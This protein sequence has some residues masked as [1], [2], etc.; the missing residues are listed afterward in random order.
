MGNNPDAIVFYGIVPIDRGDE[1]FA[2]PWRFVHAGQPMAIESETFAL[3]VALGSQL[4]APVARAEMRRRC[5]VEFVQT[6][7]EH[8][9]YRLA[10]AIRLSIQMAPEWEVTRLQFTASAPS[11]DFA[12][13]PERWP[14]IID[15]WATRL[16]IPVDV[17]GEL[18]W[19]ACVQ[20][21][22]GC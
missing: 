6:G 7:N 21:G 4:A 11:S 18:G 19:F 1:S 10:L 20:G 13:P 14:E 5:P 9:G 2:E 3:D 8:D 22:D 15:E 16:G 17:R 12:P